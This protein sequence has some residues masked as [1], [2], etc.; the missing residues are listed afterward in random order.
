MLG[1]D[2]TDH[3]LIHK[4]IHKSLHLM[5]LTKDTAVSEFGLTRPSG[6]RNYVSYVLNASGKEDQ[7]LKSKPKA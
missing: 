2:R 3:S 1:L 5:S 4:I 7:A 6:E